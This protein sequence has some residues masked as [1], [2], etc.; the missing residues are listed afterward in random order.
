MIKWQ[1]ILL[2]V[3]I[4]AG[5]KKAFDPKGALADNS[6]YLVI[7]GTINSGSDSTFIRLSRTKKFSIPIVIEKE[8]GAQVTAESDANTSYPLTEISPGTYSAASLNLDN[9]HKYR[10]R[11]K[12]ANS[13]EYLSD[14]VAIK[15]SPPIDSVG[16]IAKPNG[17]QVYV[18]THDNANNTKYYRWEYTEAWKFHTTYES[19]FEVTAPRDPSRSVYYCY[20][21]D[22]SSY[23]VLSSSAQ[24]S[25]DLIYQAPITTLSPT[26]EKIEIRYSIEVKQYAL[27]S[28]AYIF[29]TALHKNNETNGSIF[30]AQPSD[31]LTNYRCLSNPGKFVVGYLSAGS[32]STKRIFINRDQLLP[33]YNPE[34]GR[35]CS[36]ETLYYDKGY[37]ALSDTNN[38]T[39]LGGMYYSP[40]P[41]FSAPSAITYSTRDCADCTTRGA[42]KAPYFWK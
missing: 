27:T 21:K 33:G 38:Y 23:I 34:Y 18:N 2:I 31:N 37:S 32:T 26:S 35:A 9:S 5:C 6:K 42:T 36:I 40:F 16:F 12:T 3:L 22:T 28:D 19:F 29:W 13:E 14:F 8:T 25:K 30:D 4:L 11:I 17:V 10:L 1:K 39:A 24:L 20:A 41:P 15:N 7:D